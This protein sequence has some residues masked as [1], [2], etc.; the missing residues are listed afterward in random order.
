MVGVSQCQHPPVSHFL[1][2]ASTH[3]VQGL[4]IS[5]SVRSLR[6]SMSKWHLAIKGGNW[7][8]LLERDKGKIYPDMFFDFDSSFGRVGGTSR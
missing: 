2:M 1:F 4:C 6:S 5:P 7:A 8:Y 3:V